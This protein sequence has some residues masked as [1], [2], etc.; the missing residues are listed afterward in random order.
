M[1]D[2]QVAN[3]E[4]DFDKKFREC[5]EAYAYAYVLEKAVRPTLGKTGVNI[6]VSGVN[7]SPVYYRFLFDAVGR[8]EKKQGG[9]GRPIEERKQHL[10]QTKKALIAA[11]RDFDP[12]RAVDDL[13]GQA[14]AGTI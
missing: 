1:I 3:L 2:Q 10:L 6:Q 12:D 8:L 7:L 14:R 4:E 5:L 13:L 11:Q 9:D